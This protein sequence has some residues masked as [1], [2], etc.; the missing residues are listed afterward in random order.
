MG[1]SIF[2][3]VSIIC[4]LLDRYLPPILQYLF[5]GAAAAGLGEL[6]LSP[7]LGGAMRVWAGI[8]YVAVA[9]S[10]LV[11][12][13]IRLAIVRRETGIAT[14]FS[15][16]TV[17]IV[18]VSALFLSS[19]LENGG[20]L[21]FSPASIATIAVSA[22]FADISIFGLLREYS[23]HS[24]IKRGGLVPFSTGPG[25][26]TGIV[27]STPE[28]HPSPVKGFVLRQESEQGDGWEESPTKKD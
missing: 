11:A 25:L 27:G 5:H 16:M 12:V 18:M 22:L 28:L 21:V 23:R 6:L 8:V 19:F 24:T 10:S 14:I 4:A 1:V 2:L 9:L 15:Q 3:A 17:P 26:S 7:A 20:Q 13:N